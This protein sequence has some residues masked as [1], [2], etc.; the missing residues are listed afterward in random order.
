MT[1]A[2][3]PAT[4]P[5]ALV[6]AV[7]LTAWW[8][9]L[10]WTDL[11]HLRLP[12][13]DDMMRLAQIRDWTDGQAFNDLTQA[14]LGP[15]G[16][17]QLHWSRLPDLAPAL[18]IMALTPL[19]GLARAEVAAVIFWPE[20][21]FF[22]HLLL[23]G[24]LAARLG[25]RPTVL[26]A[27]ALAALAAPAV[28]LFVPGRIDHHGLQIVLVQL[29]ALGLV[30]RRTLLAGTAAGVSLLVGVEAGPVIIAAMLVLGWL[31]VRDGRAIGGFGVGMLLAALTGFAILRPAP[32]AAGQCDGFTPP[33]FA[34]MMII[35]GAG[36]VLA[37]VAPRLPDLRWRL[38]AATAVAALVLGI[39]WI[40]APA[41]FGNPYGISDP[42]LM[43][44][45]SGQVGEM[46]GV[47]AQR[48]G[49]LLAFLGMP[50][51]GLIA[52]IF[53]AVRERSARERWLLFA[54]MIGTA[55]LAALFQLRGAW[56]GAALAAP[57]LG[58]LV[59][60]AGRRGAA[61][62]AAAWLVS[63]GLVWQTLGNLTQGRDRTASTCTDASVIAALDRLDTGTFAAP[64]DLSAYLIG[65]TQHRALGGPYHR[66]AAGNRAMAEFFLSTPDQARYQASLWTIDYVALCPGKGGGLP[67]AMLRPNSLAAHLANGVA[68]DWLQPVSLIG[69][70]LP[71][72]RVRSAIGPGLRP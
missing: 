40:A 44:L 65:G 54:A 38:S 7:L 48:P 51:V 57:V 61:W 41:C 11:A 17:V 64:L 72:W 45:W 15:P 35:G 6:L 34:L 25:G 29:M 22:L 46:G 18:V 26:P 16:G 47:I 50:V 43:R 67:P 19:M 31:W 58:H 66:N 13:P 32:W 23:A 21:L 3:A 55:L 12:E 69:T 52:S 24:A 42:V 59:S 36:L 37:G 28:D 9:T 4:L 14:R 8:T 68:P 5:L 71:V 56:F 63:V 49:A 39:A 62:Q 27:I 53:F 1:S 30:D 70:D 20:L 2:R 10:A 60:L 33:M